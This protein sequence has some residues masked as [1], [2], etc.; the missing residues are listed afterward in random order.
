[1]A[2]RVRLALP[3]QQEAPAAAVSRVTPGAQAPLAGVEAVE[4]ARVVVPAVRA[5]R[6]PTPS[7]PAVQVVL[8]VRTA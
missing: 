6:A 8:V 7:E 2:E 3:E 5:A 4:A 1:M